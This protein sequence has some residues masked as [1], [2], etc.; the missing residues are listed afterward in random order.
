[1]PTIG[2]IEIP[3]PAI[4]SIPWPFVA[5]YPFGRAHKPQVVTHRMG[6][7]SANGKVSQRY[8]LGTGAK[9]FTV[10]RSNLSDQKRRDLAQFWQDNRGAEGSF[11][12]D[13]PNEDGTTSE[14]LVR[15]K[16]Q[17]LTFEFLYGAISSVGIVLVEVPTANPSYAIT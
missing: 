6:P 7:N 8:L 12:Y 17:D 9:E 11:Y 10:R 14:Y 1:M 16:E 5:D 15:F 2:N 3:S 13:A 4:S